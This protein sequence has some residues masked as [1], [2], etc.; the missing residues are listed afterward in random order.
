M[1]DIN[2]I[3]IDCFN[4]GLSISKIHQNT[5]YDH[6][7]IRKYLNKEE[8]NLTPKTS[9][10]RLYLAAIK[11]WEAKNEIILEASGCKGKI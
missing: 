8:F 3:R 1:A 9:L 4:K 2:S 6:K 10:T 7:T 5:G 11:I